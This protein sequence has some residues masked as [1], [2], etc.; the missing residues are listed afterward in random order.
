MVRDAQGAPVVI[1][2]DPLLDDG[3]PMPTTYWLVDRELNRRIGTIESDGG[4]KAAE[5]AVDPSDLARVHA[6]YAAARDAMT[7]SEDGSMIA[8]PRM[9]ARSVSA[10]MPSTAIAEASDVPVAMTEASDDVQ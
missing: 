10:T 3:T 9:S 1:R 2:N 7:P 5:A 8:S 4:V 6:A